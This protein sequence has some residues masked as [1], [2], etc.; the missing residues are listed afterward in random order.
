MDDAA[1]IAQLAGARRVVALSH[2]R[3]R[4]EGVVGVLWRGRSAV[5]ICAHRCELSE[6]PGAIGGL[7]Q[8]ERL[9]VGDNRISALPELPASLRELYVYD[10]RLAT[11]PALPKLAVLD[12][13]RN[14]LAAL[15]AIEAIDF[16]YLAA[17]RLASLPAFRGVR[18]LNVGENPL[19]HLA[20]EDAAIEELRA[21]K[22]Q[23]RSLAIERLTGLRELALRGNQLTGLPASIASLTQLRTLDLRGNQLDE[24]PEALRALPLS[25][26]DLRWNPLRAP[27]GWL[28]ELSRG[29]CLVYT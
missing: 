20:I 27:P 6:L 17:N 21:E 19:G 1:V 12:A 7:S 29:G 10:N 8:L 2:A 24:V 4:T 5:A 23:L 26:L 28:D 11:L 15:P 25:K 22:A 9:D 3:E 13:N 14:Q 18:Y 16:V